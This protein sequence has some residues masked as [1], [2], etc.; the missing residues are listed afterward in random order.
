MI[1][2][3]TENNKIVMAG[4]VVT[5]PEFSHEVYGENFYTFKLSVPRLSETV[6]IIPVTIS[7][8]FFP[9]VKVETGLNILLTGQ[10][11]SYNNFSG[12]GNRLLLTVFVKD[13]EV[14]ENLEDYASPNNVY[15]NGYI[16]KAPVYRTTP[17][18][19]EI[20]DI[21][22]AVN[23]AYNKSDYIPCIAWGR[24]AKYAEAL[25]V[26]DNIIIRG[27]VQS[28]QYQKKI[29]EEEFE[30]KVAYE[31]SVSKLELK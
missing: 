24:N 19:R 12:E 29:G 13:I 3:S 16:C 1:S 22:L 4:T 14:I 10:F 15:L 25:S 23:R 27:R 7:E 17:F 5:D 31:V 26:G 21:L 9:C 11:R 28:R 18:G 20:A 6:D 30:N 8:K 2:D